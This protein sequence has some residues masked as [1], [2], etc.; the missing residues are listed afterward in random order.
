MLPVYQS[1][2]AMKAVNCQAAVLQRN[3]SLIH[4]LQTVTVCAYLILV[5]QQTT[6]ADN[7]GFLKKQTSKLG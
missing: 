3:C 6:L 2:A 4:R 7:Q 1:Q 5:S